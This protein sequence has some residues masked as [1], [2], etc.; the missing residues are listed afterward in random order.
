V[1]DWIFP[2]ILI[3]AGIPLCFVDGRYQGDGAWQSFNQVAGPVV[4][5]MVVSL[6]FAIGGVF[7]ASAMGGIAFDE[8]VPKVIFKLC[9]VALLPAAIGGLTNNYIGGYNGN[10]ASVFAS[11]VCLFGLFMLLFRLPF[12]DQFVCVVLLFIV[13]TAV[14]YMAFRLEG[15][16][17]G[18]SI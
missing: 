4:I 2:A 7:A 1:R 14:A 16:K 9:A 17:A 12:S 15:A 11:L 5:S 10:I 13:R 3:A 18:S 6:V 8:S